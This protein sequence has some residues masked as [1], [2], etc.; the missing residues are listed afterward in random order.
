MSV[1]I[2]LVLVS[3]VAFAWYQYRVHQEEVWRRSGIA[4]ID[5][6]SGVDFEQR[7]AVLFR[8]L[9]YHVEM[10]PRTGDYGADLIVSKTNARIVVQAKRSQRTVGVKAVQEV[11][12]ALPFYGGT[13]ALVITNAMF[14]SNARTMAQ[15]L[16][17]ELWDR[18]ALVQRLAS[19]QPSSDNTV[20]IY[21]VPQQN[22]GW[23]SPLLQWIENEY[24]IHGLHGRQILSVVPDLDEE[25]VHTAAILRLDANLNVLDPEDEGLYTP[26]RFATTDILKA[27]IETIPDYGVLWISALD[28]WN[29]DI[30]IE[31]LLPWR[32]M[33]FV[34]AF[35]VHPAQVDPMLRAQ[36]SAEIPFRALNKISE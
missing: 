23:L 28:Q 5:Q 31:S 33:V 14:S 21:Q 4:A 9:G 17:V 16:G 7:L 18:S 11:V 22:G 2:F 26:D 3:G 24:R 30:L 27:H 34:L 12:S 19:T 13:Q 35:V 10:T 20:A 29:P 32:K 8:D 36:F 1:L 25:V 15:R 6:M